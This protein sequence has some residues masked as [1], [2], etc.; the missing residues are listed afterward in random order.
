MLRLTSTP[1]PLAMTSSGKRLATLF[2]PASAGFVATLS[3]ASPTNAAK[4]MVP[5]KAV[6]F[7]FCFINSESNQPLQF[8]NPNVGDVGVSLQFIQHGLRRHAV[9]VEH[10]QRLTAGGVAVQTH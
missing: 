4:A 6:N 9:Q 2:A 5:H 10:R 3:A 1:L 8:D 7:R